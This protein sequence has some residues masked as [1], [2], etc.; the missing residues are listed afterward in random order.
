[1]VNKLILMGRVGADPEKIDFNDGNYIAKIS[2][3]TTNKVKDKEITTWHSV[4]AS[5]KTAD[6]VL[7]FVKKGDLLYTEGPH[8]ITTKEVGN[9]DKKTFVTQHAYMF[10]L[11]DKKKKEEQGNLNF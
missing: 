5:G 6:N 2:L 3:A 4:Q 1:M 10:Q 9:G 7:K 8:N 11:L